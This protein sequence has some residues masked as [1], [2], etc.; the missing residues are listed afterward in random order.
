MRSSVVLM[1]RSLT[2][3]EAIQRFYDNYVTAFVSGDMQTV[4]TKYYRAPVRVSVCE[5]DKVLLR[6]TVDTS[7]ELEKAFG[8]QM[9]LL[10]ARGYAGRS[11]MQPVRII[12]LTGVS[13]LLQS[14]GLR[15]HESGDVL[16]KVKAN[17]V[18][19]RIVGEGDKEQWFITSVYSE[20]T[21]SM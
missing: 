8:H 14:E 20:V 11:D 12:P 21:P 13:K 10:L 9:E 6:T 2:S 15:Y 17:Y 3:S 16:E 1:K 18:I 7:I 4:A 19:E 5:E